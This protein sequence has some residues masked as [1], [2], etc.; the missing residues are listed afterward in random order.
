MPCGTALP[1][2]HQGKACSPSCPPAAGRPACA[3]R[4]RSGLAEGRRT[5]RHGSRRGCSAPRRRRCPAAYRGLISGR[6]ER[7]T[8][9][10]RRTRAWSAVGVA[11][12]MRHVAQLAFDG[13]LRA[14]AESCPE[15]H[16]GDNGLA[17]QRGDEGVSRESDRSHGVVITRSNASCRHHRQP[18]GAVRLETSARQ[19]LPVRRVRHPEYAADWP[20]LV[21]TMKG[22]VR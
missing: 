20:S 9:R 5:L 21:Q 17:T 10:A 15:L 8:G 11:G 16:H 13:A 2:A 7:T 12:V 18:A 14:V 3:R 22:T 4:R 19:S 1:V 6:R